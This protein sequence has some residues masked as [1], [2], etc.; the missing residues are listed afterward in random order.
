MAMS[1][2]SLTAAKGVS[3]SIANWVAYTK[4]DIPVIVDEAQALLYEMLRCREMMTEYV[5]D[6]PTGYSETPL[7]A[8]FLDPIGRIYSPT[9]NSSFPQKEQ[10]RIRA[11]RSYNTL[12]GDFLTDP[13]TTTNGSALVSVALAGHGFNQGGDITISGANAV[14][15]ITPNGTFPIVSIPDPNDFVID[16]S[17]LGNVASGAGSGGGAAAIYSCDNL[18]AVYF[19]EWAIWDE[20]IKFDGAA[21]QDLKMQLA[22]YRSL[23]LL[24]S[25]NQT[26]F[27]TTRYPNALRAACQAAAADFMKDTPEFQRIV[28][29]S[30]TPLIQR[31][32]AENEGY[33][34]G[35]EI[36]TETP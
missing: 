19:N 9:I 35:S 21:Q 33:L 31:I 15:G 30:L 3:G 7:P 14:N 18:V 28:Q 8:G 2:T 13:F 36:M 1:Y 27:L 22:Y 10:S 4:L 25:A 11:R 23:P 32:N 17:V 20:K 24:S 5:F 12:T 16:T 34:R 29:M 26:N 6:M